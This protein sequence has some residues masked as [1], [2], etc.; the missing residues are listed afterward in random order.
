MNEDYLWDKSGEPD[1]EV[2]RLENLLAPLGHKLDKTPVLSLPKPIRVPYLLAIAA[3]LLVFGGAVWVAWQRTRPAW[4][5]ATVSGTPSLKRLAK[6]ES[7]STDSESQALLNLNDVGE[8]E[9]EPNTRLSVLWAPPGRFIVNTP[10]AQTVDLGC[11]YTLK[12]DADGVGLV[13]V[14]VGWVAFENEG[15]ESF[16]PADAACITR[17]G[18]GPGIP[19]YQD[20]SSELIDALHRFDANADQSAIAV[21]IEKAR[22]RDAISL[23]H[24]LRRVQPDDRG[25]AY[26]RLAQFVTMPASVTREGGPA[27]PPKLMKTPR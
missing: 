15:R 5:V 17:P 18:K 22:T 8:V 12:V 9:V 3:S 24:L 21:I 1:P 25:R 6:G 4:Q 20:A 11:Q 7:I 2:Q 26:D 16:I 23:W 13:E 19:Y 27:G 14:S 10:S